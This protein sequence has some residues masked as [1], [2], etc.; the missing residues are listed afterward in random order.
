[1]ALIKEL[2]KDEAWIKLA[3]II[4]IFGELVSISAL[5][6]LSGVL[7]YGLTENF[8]RAIGILILFFAWSYLYL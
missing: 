3:L 7:T 8:V 4:G 6:L 1:M 5:T 2:G